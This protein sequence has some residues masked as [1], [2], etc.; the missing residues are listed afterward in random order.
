MACCEHTV[1][2]QRCVCWG[3]QRFLG[4]LVCLMGTRVAI[5][6]KVSRGKPQLSG[7]RENED[8][9]HAMT[10]AGDQGLSGAADVSDGCLG[11]HQLSQVEIGAALP[12]E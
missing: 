7:T 3:D 9:S 11:G 8:L 4:L 1:G 6:D 10:G 5:L 2:W 12:Q